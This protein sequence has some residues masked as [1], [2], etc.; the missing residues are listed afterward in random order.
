MAHQK[1][2]CSFSILQCRQ[3]IFLRYACAIIVRH[4]NTLFLQD[5]CATSTTG[6]RTYLCTCANIFNGSWTGNLHGNQAAWRYGNQAVLRCGNEIGT[7]M[8]LGRGYGDEAGWRYGNQAA[9]RYGNQA[10]LRYGNVIGT[11]IRLGRGYGGEAGWRCGLEAGRRYRNK[12][13]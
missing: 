6:H 3:N 11:G 2:H 4:T 10:V 8:R 9:W 5:V 12:A 7:G 13:G 1:P